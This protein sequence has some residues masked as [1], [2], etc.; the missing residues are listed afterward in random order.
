MPASCLT[1]SKPISRPATVGSS[2]KNYSYLLLA[3]R[4][5]SILIKASL[6]LKAYQ[7]LQVSVLT[8]ACVTRA[9]DICRR[10]L[11]IKIATEV[12]PSGW[13]PPFLVENKFSSIGL[14]CFFAKPFFF[15]ANIAYICGEGY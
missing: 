8:L 13:K 14:Y 10:K 4:T 11:L 12:V 7:N 1:N 5:L 3:G 9:Q 6:E 15:G 2:A